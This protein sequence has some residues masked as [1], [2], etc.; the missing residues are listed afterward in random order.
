MTDRP[1]SSLDLLRRA[2]TEPIRPIDVAVAIGLAVLSVIPYVSGA[3]AV[4]QRTS[5]TFGLLLLESLPLIVRRRYPLEVFLVVVTASIVQIALVSEGQQVTAGLGILVAMY[6]IGERLERHVSVPLAALAGMVVGVILLGSGSL[7]GSLQSTI[8]TEVI[9]VVAWLVGD[10]ARIRRL[11]A[12]SLEERAGLLDREREERTRRAALEERERIARELH[13]VVGH[14]VSVM[15]VQAGGALTAFDKRPEDARAA[16]AAIGTAGRQAL[17]DMRRLIGILGQ[18]D[19]REPMPRLEQLDALVERVRSAGLQVELTIEGDPRPLDPGLEL[20][21]YRI[22]QEGLTNSLRHALGGRTSI[23][24][25]YGTD[26]L[27]IT[28]D[29]TG[30]GPAAAI[31]PDHEGRGLLGMRERVAMFRG[32]LEAGPTPGGFRVVAR[33]PFPASAGS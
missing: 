26:A 28:I 16:L 3:Q 5:V 2:D 23:I 7:P 25:R 32:S 4:D 30:G 21:T 19:V 17:V 6:T 24:V 8:Q 1:S 20:S 22:V 27:E 15:V 13:D 33:L 12:K 29:D 14:H 18:E 31:E 11:Y 10:A 9:L